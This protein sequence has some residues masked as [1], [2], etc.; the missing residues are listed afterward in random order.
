MVAK[1]KI[2]QLNLSEVEGKIVELA[3]KGEPPEKI[4]LI[5]RDIYGTPKIKGFGKKV[6]QV[7]NDKGVNVDSEKNN[8]E[9]KIERLKEHFDKNKH[10]YYVQ[11][12]ITRY[13]AR[14][15]KIKKLRG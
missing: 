11:R 2:S 6:S 4:G 13:S 3:K 5:L 8:L 10:D 9:K 14:L 7:L 12:A 1:Q 15:R